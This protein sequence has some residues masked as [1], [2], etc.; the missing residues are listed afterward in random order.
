MY[1]WFLN[2]I[3]PTTFLYPLKSLNLHIGSDKKTCT[4]MK[5]PIVALV[6][7]NFICFCRKMTQKYTL[8]ALFKQLIN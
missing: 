3:S 1:A 8:S 7:S 4:T 2:S 5:T 6:S